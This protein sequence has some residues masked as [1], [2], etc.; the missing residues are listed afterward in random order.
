[1][2]LC[3]LCIEKFL[4]IYSFYLF[5]SEIKMQKIFHNNRIIIN[6]LF[7]YFNKNYIIILKEVF[8]Y[9]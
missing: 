7:I 3:I 1:M 2:Y 9:H 8:N 5:I 4:S 6:I